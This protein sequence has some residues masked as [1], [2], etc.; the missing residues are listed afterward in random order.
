MT[1]GVAK[2]LVKEAFSIHT[3]A[4]DLISVVDA[5][6]ASEK[7]PRVFCSR[8]SLPGSATDT[9]KDKTMIGA[10]I[11]PSRKA[12]NILSMMGGSINVEDAGAAREMHSKASQ[13]L[14][15]LLLKKQFSQPNFM[16]GG[17]MRSVH[18]QEVQCG[19]RRT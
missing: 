3:V 13:L 8:A 15:R 17:R 9:P 11:V 6:A 16:L 10:R 12:L 14:S 4:A 1:N 19:V 7:P 18:C 5:P 2:P